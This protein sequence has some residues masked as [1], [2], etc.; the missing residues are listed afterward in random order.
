MTQNFSINFF[1]YQVYEKKLREYDEF[2][3]FKGGHDELYLMLCLFLL[4]EYKT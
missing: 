4:F 1:I 3:F 2:I